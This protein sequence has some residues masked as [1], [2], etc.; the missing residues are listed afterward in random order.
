MVQINNL[1]KNNFYMYNT[2]KTVKKDAD[3]TSKIS[4]KGKSENQTTQNQ[5]NKSVHVKVQTWSDTKGNFFLQSTHDNGTITIRCW[6]DSDGV[7]HEEEIHN[8][9]TYYSREQDGKIIEEYEK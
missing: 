2:N 1:G 6:V 3:A 4:E 9:D 8:F 7:H 5:K